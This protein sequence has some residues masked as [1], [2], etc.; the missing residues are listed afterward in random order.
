LIG[1]PGAGKGTQAAAIKAEI[2]PHL[3]SGD[4]FREAMAQGTPL[5]LEVKR[6]V[7]SGQLVPDE[8]TVA[9][10]SE[11]LAKDDARGGALLDGFPRT[12]GQAEAL[13]R[14]LASNGSQVDQVLYL[15]VPEEELVRRLAGR[16][17]CRICQTPYHEV[18]QP[19]KVA[20]VC[21]RDGGEL[22]QRP[23]DTAETVRN[24]LQVFFNQTAPLIEYYQSRG[25]LDQID[26]AQD[27]A[28]VSEAVL[29]AVKR[30]KGV[31]A[32]GRD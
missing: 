16:W 20:G 23:D 8:L 19:P 14:E 30:R 1:A 18:F 5:G 17:L 28:S 2:G 29:N 31:A 3:A 12:V 9:M 21:D 32:R 6:Y 10:V 25:V 27:V 7:E 24:R 13:D 26:G 15:A 22:F 4:M 11:R